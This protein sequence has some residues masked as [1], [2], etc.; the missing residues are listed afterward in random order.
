MTATVVVLMDDVIQVAVGHPGKHPKITQLY[1][2]NVI[3][4]GSNFG[5][6][7]AAL[8]ELWG[9]YNLPKKHIRVVLPSDSTIMNISAIGDTKKPTM[10][11][12]SQEV[13]TKRG[14]Q[15]SIIDHM[16]F[17][18]NKIGQQLV[19]SAACG[20]KDLE[21]YVQM[22]EK[23]DM[24][25]DSITIPTACLM[26]LQNNLPQFK[27]ETCIWLAFEDYNVTTI[28]L[29]GGTYHYSGRNHVFSEPGTNDFGVEVTRNVSGTL[30]FW[31]AG[32]QDGRSIQRLYFSGCSDDN[33]WICRDGLKDLGL[34]VMPLE[35]QNTVRLPDECHLRDWIYCVGAMM[36]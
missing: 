35:N 2:K 15:D 22:F 31:A 19:L 20:Q 17:G 14:E 3:T 36:D 10:D 26:K 30:Q 12:L 33:F 6:W 16:L 5:P 23:L 25:I 18:R 28:V 24:S 21:K 29:D 27:A 4:T 32:N 11:R 13:A 34:D 7:Q 1:S 9:E 8:A